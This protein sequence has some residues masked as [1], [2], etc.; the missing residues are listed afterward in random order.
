MATPK[1]LG[2]DANRRLP[3]VFRRHLVQRAEH[4][5][6]LWGLTPLAL[7]LDPSD[8]PRGVVGPVKPPAGVLGL[9]RPD[10]RYAPVPHQE[11]CREIASIEAF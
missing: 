6:D 11:E 5:S 8:V 4:D 10:L 3:I 9:A 2:T 1:Q 7:S